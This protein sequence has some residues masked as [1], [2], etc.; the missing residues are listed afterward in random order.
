MRTFH[1]FKFNL[2]QRVFQNALIV[3]V[4]FFGSFIYLQKNCTARNSIGFYCNWYARFVCLQIQIEEKSLIDLGLVDLFEFKTHTH[5]HCM[6]F[7][8]ISLNLMCTLHFFGVLIVRNNR[9]FISFNV[10]RACCFCMDS[11]SRL[12]ILTKSG[13][14]DSETAV[15]STHFALSP[16]G[17][18]QRAHYS[19]IECRFVYRTKF[20]YIYKFRLAT[21][22]VF[23]ARL[24]HMQCA[25]TATYWAML[26]EHIFLKWISIE[27]LKTNDI[28]YK[29]VLMNT[30]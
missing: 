6:E 16:C 26:N 2:R 30:V 27:K 15:Q 7:Y 17:R 4:A 21:Y 12:N 22:E 11:L 8:W 1:I 29:T 3:G 25:H 18:W 20:V 10:A 14:V 19:S 5:T 13:L 9:K 24:H 28:T 23:D